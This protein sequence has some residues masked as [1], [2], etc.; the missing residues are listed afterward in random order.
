[1]GDERP[2][3]GGWKRLAIVAVA[4]CVVV[5]AA[6]FLSLHAGV[7]RRPQLGSI[8]VHTYYAVKLKS[9]RTEY[10]DAGDQIV[11]CSNSLL[12]QLGVSPC[13]Y[14]SRHPTQQITID[15]GNPNNPHTF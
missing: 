10:D 12:P 2:K 11:S 5:Y 13:W 9:G 7:P 14:V 1:M 8:T 6:D 15:S 3:L 4:L